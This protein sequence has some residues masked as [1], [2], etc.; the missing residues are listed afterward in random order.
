MRTDQAALA[1]VLV[2]LHWSSRGEA[3]QRSYRRHQLA[4]LLSLLSLMSFMSPGTTFRFLLM[5]N[6][7][8][9]APP[10]F[11]DDT[12]ARRA[13]A[14]RAVADTL[15][16]DCRRCCCCRGGY[17]H[18][19]PSRSAARLR[20]YSSCSMALRSSAALSAC[21]AARAS[22]SLSSATSRSKASA[23]AAS[24]RSPACSARTHA[25]AAATFF[26]ATTR[27]SAARPVRYSYSNREMVMD[28]FPFPCANLACVAPS[29]A[30]FN[31]R[32]AAA[33]AAFAA[34][35][36]LTDAPIRASLTAASASAVSASARTHRRSIS[37]S[38][39][40]LSAALVSARSCW[41]ADVRLDTIASDRS[42]APAAVSLRARA[43]SSFAFSSCTRASDSLS[44]ALSL[45]TSSVTRTISVR[46]LSMAV[47]NANPSALTRSSSSLA[48][49][50]SAS[51]AR[52][53]ARSSS[54]FST[55]PLLLAMARTSSI[56]AWRTATSELVTASFASISRTR[57][58]SLRSAS[59]L[60]L[61]SS[62]SFA[63]RSDSARRWASTSRS[64]R[65]ASIR[66]S[67]TSTCSSFASST[68]RFI[69]SA[70][71]RSVWIFSA[72]ATM[73]LSALAF[74]SAADR[75][76]SRGPAPH[77]PPAPPPRRRRRRDPPRAASAL[78]RA[79]TSGTPR[80]PWLARSAAPA[81][82]PWRERA[83]APTR[84]RRAPCPRR[85]CVPSAYPF[86]ISPGASFLGTDSAYTKIGGYLTHLYLSKEI[87]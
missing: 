15:A 67:S 72:A 73:S 36:S 61:V 2:L 4:A 63:C 17:A 24:S 13:L 51:A 26:S 45:A 59:I 53:A 60:A 70:A 54:S 71:R 9:R 46:V 84:R 23:R 28:A 43:L 3:E 18:S 22:F 40:S 12:D 69:S 25:C 81:H 85:P 8:A 74:A 6:D 58:A 32:I 5:A 55:T 35:S 42:L 79:L 21:S 38:S 56:C 20:S 29:T 80:G 66:A 1:L 65:S 39:V 7:G 83:T 10:P 57:P 44:R 31:L 19:S 49:P 77:A 30:V 34:S 86:R 75:A 52:T 62:I 68:S 50:S 76:A 16:P 27:T 78:R 47:M 82:A 41:R 14:L 33:S 87:T 37:A 48:A 11:A 64:S